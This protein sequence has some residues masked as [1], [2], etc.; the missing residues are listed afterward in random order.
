MRVAGT[1]LLLLTLTTPAPAGFFDFLFGGDDGAKSQSA[2]RPNQPT[3]SIFPNLFEPERPVAPPPQS[4]ID[5][6]G[7]RSN[8]THCV[9]MCDG[10]HFP[11]LNRGGNSPVAMCQA[12]CPASEAKVFFGSTI[13]RAISMDGER[14]SETRNAYAY[15]K[16]LSPGCTCNGRD[17]AGLAPVDLSM[18]S[19]LRPGDIIATGTGLVAYS[20]P[21]GG[22]GGDFT[23]VANYNGLTTEVRARLGEIKVMPVN[24]G[25]Q[26][27]YTMSIDAA[28][29]MESETPRPALD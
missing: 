2:K 23:P 25:M 24:A 1:V 21:R 19:T 22:R 27:E 10:K 29:T 8:F 4:T 20:G 14:Y 9:R 3:D 5:S 16:A 12:F 28:R 26:E 11:L 18:D 13:D 15:R 17:P 6:G 7:A